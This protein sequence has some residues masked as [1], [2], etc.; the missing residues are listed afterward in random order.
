MTNI[1]DHCVLALG[2]IKAGLNPRNWSNDLF[3]VSFRE[4]PAQDYRLIAHKETK[5]IESFPDSMRSLKK[6]DRSARIA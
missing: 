5:L 2:L 4:L 6:N 1:Y 3:F